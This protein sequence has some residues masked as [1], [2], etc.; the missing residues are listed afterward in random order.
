MSCFVMQSV[1]SCH[2]S[3]A[4]ISQKKRKQTA[5]HHR[6]LQCKESMQ[7]RCEKGVLYCTYDQHTSMTPRI[8]DGGTQSRRLSHLFPTSQNVLCTAWRQPVNAAQNS[9]NC[10]CKVLL[11]SAACGCTTTKFTNIN[12]KH[13]HLLNRLFA[14]KTVVLRLSA[15]A[16]ALAFFDPT[17]LL[18]DGQPLELFVVL[19]R[20]TKN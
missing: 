3:S 5:E 9:K 1:A 18:R 7:T 15:L 17:A 19:R 4:R 13:S 16:P 6:R 20:S 10:K 11:Y 2:R 8:G 12:T 14:E